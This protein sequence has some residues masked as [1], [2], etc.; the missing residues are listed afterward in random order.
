[1][2]LKKFFIKFSK[3]KRKRLKSLIKD[4][5]MFVI[6]AAGAVLLLNDMYFHI[7]FL[8][9]S[10]E[11][12]H[13]LGSGAKPYV[14]LNDGEVSVSYIDVGQGDCQLIRT[15]TRNILI[16][17]GDI[18]CEDDV[19]GF[20][21]YSGVDYLD[22]VIA[23]HPHTDHYGA[24]YRV[25]LNFDVGLFLMPELPDEMI[26]YG[27]TYQRLLN[28]IHDRGITAQYASAGDRYLLDEN[29]YLD[30]LSPQYY[31]YKDLNDF[32]ITAKLVHGDNSFLFTG[33]LQEYSELDLIS[34]GVDLDADVLKVGHHGSAGASSEEFLSE[35]TPKIAIFD[36]AEYNSY[37]HPRVD[38]LARLYN[39]GCK[40]TYSTANNGNIVIVSDG[41][42]LKVEVEKESVLELDEMPQ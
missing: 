7:P 1:M 18:D 21:K 4:T 32:S 20:L 41:V 2:T 12:V 26:P 9:T 36:V 10:E 24:M 40:T 35:V 29:C 8:P 33:D 16:D 17:S 15:G 30:I 27:L 13:F 31:D 23:T 34:K 19:I 11:A 3:A 39:V 6:C 5:A 42:N 28:V 37:R 25:L 22:M 14:K 38:V